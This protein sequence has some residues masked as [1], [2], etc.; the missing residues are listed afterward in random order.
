MM[1]ILYT[2]KT[3]DDMTIN[4][5]IENPAAYTQELYIYIYVKG[6]IKNVRYYMTK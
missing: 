6:L 2:N 3:V 4:E 1:V 5:K